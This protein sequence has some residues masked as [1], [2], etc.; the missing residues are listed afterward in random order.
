MSEVC[1]TCGLPSELCVCENIAKEQ[2]Q[3]K[4]E[5][6][7]RKF[8]KKHTIITGIDPKAIDLKDLAKQ[9]KNELAC[10]GSCKDGQIELLGD[11]RE[12]VIMILSKKGFSA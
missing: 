5:V 7:K 1:P 2:Q 11:H 6:V 3:I 4:V 8:G 10:G 12:Q 9:L